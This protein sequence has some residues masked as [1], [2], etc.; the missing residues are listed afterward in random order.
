MKKC[1]V[2]FGVMAMILLPL[3]SQNVPDEIYITPSEIWKPV[4]YTLEWDTIPNARYRLFKAGQGVNNNYWLKDTNGIWTSVILTNKDFT[5]FYSVRSI[6]NEEGPLVT[7]VD[8]NGVTNTYRVPPTN[9]WS[10]DREDS[11][12]MVLQGKSEAGVKWYVVAVLN[13]TNMYKTSNIVGWPDTWNTVSTNG[14]EIRLKRIPVGPPM[15]INHN[16]PNQPNLKT[17]K[18][19]K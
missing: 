15:F 14:F 6:P 17:E 1:F 7:Y 13:N 9:A 12:T 16:P 10:F 8:V 5:P 3:C 19:L 18:R 2:F 4:Q 11:S